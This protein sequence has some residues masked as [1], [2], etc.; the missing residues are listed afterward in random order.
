MKK[1]NFIKKV[2]PLS[3][4]TF[5][6]MQNNIEEE[7]SQVNSQLAERTAELKSMMLNIK[8]APIPLV[9]AVGDGI[10]DDTDAIEG[11]LNFAKINNISTVFAPDGKYR[12]TRNID[13][14]YGIT[15]EGQQMPK[16]A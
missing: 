2:T 16:L 5:N 3:A 7:F 1:I 4:D 10:N 12:I 6:Q 8:Y 9:R 15:F 14:P 11:L 13:I